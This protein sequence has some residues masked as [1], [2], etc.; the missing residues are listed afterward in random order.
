MRNR[1]PYSETVDIGGWLSIGHGTKTGDAAMSHGYIF[2]PKGTMTK[3]RI[4][5][6]IDGPIDDLTVGQICETS[7]KS[8]QAY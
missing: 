5:H 7:G 6:S 8:R 2:L 1:C 3:F 4:L